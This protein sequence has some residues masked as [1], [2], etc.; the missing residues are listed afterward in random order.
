MIQPLW[1]NDKKFHK[2]FLAKIGFPVFASLSHMDDRMVHG[3]LVV[4]AY[5]RIEA[6]DVYILNSLA[7]PGLIV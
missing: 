1:R 4:F 3:E 2:A 6:H 7:F 5:L